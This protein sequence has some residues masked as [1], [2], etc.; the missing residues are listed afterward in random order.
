MRVLCPACGEKARVQTSREIS[1][2][3]RRVYCQCTNEACGWSGS[4]LVAITHTLTPSR[5]RD[6][7]HRLPM[8]DDVRNELQ[9]QLDLHQR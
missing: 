8:P 5:L 6:Q 9:Y 1:L 2:T 7:V 3:T 4:A